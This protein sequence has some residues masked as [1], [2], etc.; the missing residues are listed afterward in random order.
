VEPTYAERLRAAL[1]PQTEPEHR[2]CDYLAAVTKLQ[3]TTLLEMIERRVRTTARAARMDVAE[4]AVEFTRLAPGSPPDIMA[5]LEHYAS[6]GGDDDDL[7]LMLAE[8]Y[9]R[10][11]REGVEHGRAGGSI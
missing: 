11:W 2:T 9:E 10:G 3:A 5:R 8:S 6:G 1:R 4:L 7:A